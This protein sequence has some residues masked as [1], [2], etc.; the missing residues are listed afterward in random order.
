M[1]VL[2]KTT[3]AS[4]LAVVAGVMPLIAQAPPPSF[5]AA[6]VRVA[7]KPPRRGGLVALDA[8]P[9][10]LRYSNITLRNLIAMAY[11]FD[12][13]LILGGPA[14]LDSEF[15]EL[16]A[17]L[18][19]QTP[20]DRV[21]L[22]LRTLLAERFNLTVHREAREQ[23]VYFY[24]L[25]AGK[26]GPKLKAAVPAETG[27]VQTVRGDRPPVQIFSGGIVG[28]A[29]PIT[30]FA[31]ALALAAGRQVIDRTGLAGAFD[32]KLTWAPENS[33]GNGPDLFTAIQ[34]QLGLKLEPG[35]APVETLLIDHA[36]RI[37]ADN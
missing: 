28:H 15:Y 22:M 12:S 8:D 16:A 11:N 19:P 7:P 35:K 31:A 14:W 33:D 27:D 32:L 6:T 9:A 26:N 13:R 36:D 37:P 30:T 34:E 24:F 1:Q 2:K 5:E 21:P 25:V 10:M 3:R 17:K 20:K 23:S 18:P 29:M 4:I